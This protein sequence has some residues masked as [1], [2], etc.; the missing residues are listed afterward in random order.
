[1]EKCKPRQNGVPEPA[2]PPAA[3]T[4]GAADAQVL[5]LIHEFSQPLTAISN[6]AQAGRHLIDKGLGDTERLREL[7]DKIVTQ[8]TRTFI[9]NRALSEVIHRQDL[10][11]AEDAEDLR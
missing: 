2:R 3:V 8:C 10:A 7:F 5:R 1:M 9:I 6:Y 11:S 4:S